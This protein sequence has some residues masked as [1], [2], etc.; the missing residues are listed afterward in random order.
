MRPPLDRTRAR[1]PVG[2]VLLAAT[3]AASGAGCGR[4]KRKFGAPQEEATAAP[5]GQR[6]SPAQNHAAAVTLGPEHPRIWVRAADLPR[7]RSWASPS[8]PVYKSGLEAVAVEAKKTFDP[9]ALEKGSECSIRGIFCETYAELFAFMSLVAPD[10]AQRKDYGERAKAIVVKLF[11]RIDRN[12]PSD[13]IAGPRFA[14]YDRSRWTGEAFPV[15]VDWI[16]P[17]LGP[18]DKALARRV[19]LRWGEELLRAQVTSHNHPEPFGVINSPELV[20]APAKR[21]YALN[22]YFNAHMRNLGLMALALDEADDPAEPDQARAYPRLRDYLGNAVG[23]WLYMADSALR[24]E[25]AGGSSPEGFEYGSQTLAYQAQF[26][27]ALQTA[28]AADVGKLGAQVGPLSK[29]PVWQQVLPAY[30]H[31][32]SPAPVVYESWKGE[33]YQPAYYGDGQE[34]DAGDP[35]DLLAPFALY[36][37]NEGEPAK[38]AQARWLELHLSEGGTKGM[39]RRSRSLNSG[40]NFRQSIWYFLLFDPAAPPA[41]D[42]RP[43]YGL[44]HVSEGL[45]HL[46]ARTGWGRDA[47]WF[48]FQSGWRAIDH[49]HGDVNNFSF[50]R[51]GEFLT[52]E[53]VGYGYYFENS[54]QHN[55]LA[56]E[57]EKPAHT[58]D[59]RRS[60]FWKRGSQWPLSPA[61]DGKLLAK[62]VGADYAYALSD[63]TALYNSDY[64][65]IKAVTHAS[66]SIAWLGPDY[67]VV[68]DRAQSREG[69]FK[70]FFLHTAAV[71]AVAGN[72]STVTTPKGQKLVVT[73]LLPEKA[74]IAG[75]AHPPGDSSETRPA[76]Q[77]P[78]RAFL[79]VTAEGAP[80][81]ARF[82][83][84]LQGVSAGGRPD[85]AQIVRGA[86]G[87][88]F[89]GAAFGAH[90]VVFP[91]EVEEKGASATTFVVPAGVKRVLVTGLAP[92]G[93]YAVGKKPSG[94]GTEVS[95]GPGGGEKADGGGVLAVAL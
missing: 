86:G 9:Q 79:R 46:S 40:V 21:R 78:M 88:P 69:L 55:T 18:A 89:A 23:A 28:G 30:A 41:A 70:R 84:V 80:K 15:V 93:A 71:P 48:F 77:E 54:D 50:Y 66:R 31:A 38:A 61:G 22:N 75:Q 63:A 85:A 1:G 32:L 20:K 58:D 57:N 13:P 37:I 5:E 67:V 65:R 4:L 62:S 81:E 49:Q 6:V 7:L 87:A 59:D 8:N 52:K 39:E 64:E 82:L 53:R 19:F 43:S 94:G 92:G 60:S 34:F 33:E 17:L 26:H 76:E 2:F 3:L 35:I 74:Q 51:G 25:A 56:L 10:P 16:Y 12:D 44:S 47:G 14:T 72:V 29:H 95:V 90:A 68:Y 42:P 36:A 83:H 27:L 11:Q 73:T 24:T 45:G 91:V